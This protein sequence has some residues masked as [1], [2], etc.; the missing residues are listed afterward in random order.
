MPR[1]TP[2]AAPAC[3]APVQYAAKKDASP[4]PVTLLSTCWYSSCK[5]IGYPNACSAH[6]LV[7]GA[8]SRTLAD[9]W[10][11][12]SR[13]KMSMIFMSSFMNVLKVN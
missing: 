12:Y 13:L 5:G 6:A 3:A 2:S 7:R 11:L 9:F 8:P 4:I 1:H 10:L